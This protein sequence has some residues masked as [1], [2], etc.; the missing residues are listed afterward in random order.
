MSCTE[1]IESLRRAGNKKAGA[2]WLEAEAEAARFRA[3][4]GRRTVRIR[5]ENER[6]RAGG[7]DALM[8][9]A[10]AGARARARVLRLDAEQ[11]V[12]GRLFSAASGSLRRLCEKD[13]EKTFEKLARELPSLDWRVVRVNP[14]DA[15][16][17]R[18]YF[19]DAEL[20]TDANISGGMDAATEGDA[21]RVVN[22][23][24]KRLERAWP[25]LLPVLMKEVFQEANDASPANV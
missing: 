10:V 15:G 9:A 19:P 13:G 4:L 23:L 7:A 6:T 25:D 21:I 11:A 24:E 5:E 18:K 14:G 20:V 16:Y 3:E 12:S 22:T 17:A 2:L 8:K 1:L